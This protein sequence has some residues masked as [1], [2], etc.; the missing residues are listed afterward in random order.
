MEIFYSERNEKSIHTI[1]TT[2]KSEDVRKNRERFN[3]ILKMLS[4]EFI[5]MEYDKG[6]ELL[7]FAKENNLEFSGYTLFPHKKGTALINI[8]HWGK[9]E[10]KPAIFLQCYDFNK[11]GTFHTGHFSD[12]DFIVSSHFPYLFIS[13]IDTLP[14]HNLYLVW[15]AKRL[16]EVFYDKSF[17]VKD[18]EYG[19]F[20]PQ[21][22]I[23]LFNTLLPEINEV[24]NRNAHIRIDQII[25]KD[26]V[27]G[28][29]IECNFKEYI[30]NNNISKYDTYND[31]I[32]M[33]LKFGK[34]YETIR[35]H[36]KKYGL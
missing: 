3:K 12:I 31:A 6:Q 18:V 24:M 34:P 17:E 19:Y 26:I 29:E 20:L 2:I 11:G 33:C 25:V 35:K 30:I 4:K 23:D 13:T 5:R 28:K 7:D 36:I 14:I 16:E 21:E 1:N 27:L 10:V 32:K 8:G 22:D 15:I 9:L